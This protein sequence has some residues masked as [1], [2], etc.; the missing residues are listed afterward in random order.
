MYL[1]AYIVIKAE[2]LTNDGVHEGY[3]F[4]DEDDNLTAYNGGNARLMVSSDVL[5]SISK[6]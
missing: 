2:R 5:Q 3:M 4:P 1:Y 6:C